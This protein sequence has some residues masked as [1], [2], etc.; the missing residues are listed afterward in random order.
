MDSSSD[1]SSSS[2]NLSF[3]LKYP[4][5]TVKH[6]CD[7]V[8]PKPKKTQKSL[9]VVEAEEVESDKSLE[10]PWLSRN[11]HF[12][13][14]VFDEKLIVCKTLDKMVGEAVINVYLTEEN[15]FLVHSDWKLFDTEWSD[16]SV[17]VFDNI[18]FTS[19]VRRNLI[20]VE[21]KYCEMDRK[22]SRENHLYVCEKLESYAVSLTIQMETQ[23]L[24]KEYFEYFV[25]SCKDILTQ[26]SLVLLLRQITV[27]NIQQIDPLHI[28]MS[29][30][31]LYDVVLQLGDFHC[32]V[33]DSKFEILVKKIVATILNPHTG[34]LFEQV[35]T[36]LS[37]SGRIVYQEWKK[38]RLVL[39]FDP[40]KDI[41]S[42]YCTRYPLAK[43]NSFLP[44]E[45]VW[46]QD[47]QLNSMYNQRTRALQQEYE[48][49]YTQ[50]PQLRNIL[51][52]YLKDILVRKPKSPLT[53]TSMY[54]N[55]FL[56]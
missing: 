18:S 13:K 38:K 2:S 33:F 10:I 36:F 47:M 30:G 54:F 6:P 31:K 12:C 49:F 27:L 45:K 15:D 52:D 29:D 43:P 53:Y 51:R 5:F 24:I 11:R 25:D 19:L 8:P 17:E 16:A 20:T 14:I 28:L 1:D 26:G 23:T 56:I 7:G 4:I 39:R 42:Y 3:K 35:T 40:R 9:E 44:L 55:E 50:H 37:G 46:R 21:E 22:L 48:T 32:V 34:E 41:T